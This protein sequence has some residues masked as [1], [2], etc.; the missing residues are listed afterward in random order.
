M[1]VTAASAQRSVTTQ[2]YSTGPKPIEIKPTER[3]SAHLTQSSWAAALQ[4]TP[5]S[6]KYGALSIRGHERERQDSVQKNELKSLEIGRLWR[7]NFS[8]DCWKP[9]LMIAFLLL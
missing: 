7:S 2:N 3:R 1:S 9:C 6:E 8:K 5:A 4:S